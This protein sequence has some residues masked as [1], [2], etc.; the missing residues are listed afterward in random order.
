MDS[1]PGFVLGAYMTLDGMNSLMTEIWRCV[2]ISKN[3]GEKIR[4]LIHPATL[5]KLIGERNDLF[6]SENGLMEYGWTLWGVPVI[7]DSSI[8]VDSFWIEEDK[9]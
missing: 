3:K 7:A 5:Y 9:D 2:N 1:R 8:V 6:I 4:I